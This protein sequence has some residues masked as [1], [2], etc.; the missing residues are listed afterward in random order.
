[1][2]QDRETQPEQDKT[3]QV[4]DQLMNEWLQGLSGKI[5]C[6]IEK[7]ASQEWIGEFQRQI[8]DSLQKN[9]SR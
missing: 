6:E 2:E 3:A 1:M 8:G 7:L 5:S 4:S 9:C